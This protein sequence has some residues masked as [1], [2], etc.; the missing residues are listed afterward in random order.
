MVDSGILCVGVLCI[1][2]INRLQYGEEDR[3]RD[4]GGWSCDDGIRRCQDILCRCIAKYANY[5]YTCWS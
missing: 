4:A 1:D 3:H 5:D 2:A